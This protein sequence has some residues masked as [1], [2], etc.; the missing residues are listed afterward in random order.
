MAVICYPSDLMEEEWTILAA[1][2][3]SAWARG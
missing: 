1:A 3:T 2:L